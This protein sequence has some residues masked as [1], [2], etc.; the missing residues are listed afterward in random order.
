MDRM[1]R[2]KTSALASLGFLLLAAACTDA[3]KCERGQPGCACTLDDVCDDGAVCV[4][5]MCEED[6]DSDPP[7]MDGGRPPEEDASMPEEDASMPDPV[8]CTGETLEQ[9]CAS[10]CEALCQNQ[11]RHCLDSQ[12]EPNDCEAGD[13]SVTT[14]YDVC[15]DQCEGSDDPAACAR[16][17]CRMQRDQSC[18]DFGFDSGDVFV[19][20]CFAN[21]PV[22]SQAPDSGCTDVCGTNSN[23]TGGD[24]ADNGICEDGGPGSDASECGRGTD[25]TDCGVRMCAASGARCASNGDCCGFFGEGA[26]CVEVPSLGP[27]CLLNCSQSRE[28]PMPFECLPIDDNENFVCA[29]PQ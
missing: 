27:T 8:A 3:G 28:C 10:F 2:I 15:I 20:G 22:C 4:E 14:V 12:C 13:G 7:D 18:P 16:S 11:E 1:H 9:A 29:P 17:R 26:F 5:G 23:E 24:L 19:S 6:P 21:D 25:C